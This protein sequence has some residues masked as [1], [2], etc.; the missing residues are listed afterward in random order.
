MAARMGKKNLGRVRR[1]GALMR[2][3]A[4]VSACAGGAVSALAWREPHDASHR[5]PPWA[6]SWAAHFPPRPYFSLGFS[7]GFYNPQIVDDLWL[8]RWTGKQ[9]TIIVVDKWRYYRNLIS[10]KQAPEYTDYV[11]QLLQNNFHKIYSQ[12]E[13]YQIYARNTRE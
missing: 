11:T 7:L 2:N 4:R 1:R 9:P 10:A 13:G 5:S 3:A 6:L 8:G 12:E